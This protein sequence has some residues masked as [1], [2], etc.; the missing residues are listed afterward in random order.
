[1]RLNCVSRQSRAR[2]LL[3]GYTVYTVNR[4]FVIKEDADRHV[5]STY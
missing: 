4:F 2:G 3:Y 1:M 5:K